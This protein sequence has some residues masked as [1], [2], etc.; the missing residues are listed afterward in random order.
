MFYVCLCVVYMMCICVYKQCGIT[1]NNTNWGSLTSIIICIVVHII[2]LA[3]VGRWRNSLAYVRACGIFFYVLTLLFYLHRH[4]TH[5]FS[6]EL[7]GLGKMTDES[8]N[9]W[10]SIRICRH[11]T[12]FSEF[13]FCL[14]TTKVDGTSPEKFF[15][16]GNAFF[17]HL[18]KEKYRYNA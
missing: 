17:H 13:N 5:Y 9:S 1:S 18:T 6:P 12:W 14:S 2:L 10:I 15:L 7:Y 4:R 8:S 11:H 3:L 16:Y